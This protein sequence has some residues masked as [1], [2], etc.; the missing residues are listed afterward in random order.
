MFMTPPAGVQRRPSAGFT[1]LELL[2]ASAVFAVVLLVVAVGVLRFTHDY[3]KGITSSQTQE[4]AR[5]IMAEVSQAIQFGKSITV[6]PADGSG[7]AGLCVDNALYSYKVGQQ[8]TDSSP[9]A[10]LHQGYH[11]LVVD[12]GASCSAG[13]TPSIPDTSA[14]PSGSREL[15]GQHMRLSA[16]DVTSA[17]SGV[18]TVRVRVI[19][20]DD[21]L[22]IPGIS[23]GVTWAD[24]HCT[25]DAGTQFCAVSD[26]TTSVEQR[27]L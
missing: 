24:E 17:A 11:A 3:Y 8:V 9:N 5:S 26:L 21:D 6:I 2:I 22:L 7:V 10:S 14:L 1:I 19:Y 27:L 15:L 12:T 25:S 18:Y 4:T 20:G 16:L 23:G 13:A